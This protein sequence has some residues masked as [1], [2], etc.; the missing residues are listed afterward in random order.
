[1]QMYK[2]RPI[3]SFF[4]DSPNNP[5]GVKRCFDSGLILRC[6]MLIFVVA[7]ALATLQ[8]QGQSYDGAAL[9]SFS[10]S[11]GQTGS[12]TGTTETSSDMQLQKQQPEVAQAETDV[13]TGYAAAVSDPGGSG[14]DQTT[15]STW[16]NSN[17]NM[18]GER[19]RIFWDELPLASER[20]INAFSL[21]TNPETGWT[22]ARVTF[23][24]IWC[25][26]FCIN[27]GVIYYP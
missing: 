24:I 21:T 11:S 16:R 19:L 18:L 27:G 17:T 4:T 13:V 2:N 25:F 20:I 23:S 8:A 12:G 7:L 26:C 9:D 1:M 6:W 3:S 5:L 10:V 22:G 14:Y 15:I